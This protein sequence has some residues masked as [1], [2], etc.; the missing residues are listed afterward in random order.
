MLKKQ[1]VTFHSFYKTII[2]V[3]Y[4]IYYKPKFQCLKKIL[5]NMKKILICSTKNHTKIH[6]HFR[7]NWYSEWF[8]FLLTSK[9]SQDDDRHL[10]VIKKKKY[11]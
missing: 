2:Q 6:M 8:F 7:S 11:I 10:K 1:L 4:F 3:S 5:L 9:S